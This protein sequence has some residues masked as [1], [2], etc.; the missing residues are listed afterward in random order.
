[1]SLLPG[2][3]NVLRQRICEL[4]I[5]LLYPRKGTEM[6]NRSEIWL[7]VLEDLG[8]TCSVSTREDALYVQT[9]VSAE[10]DSFFTVTLPQFA[11]DLEKSL[12]TGELSSDSFVGFGRRTLEL[13]VLLSPGSSDFNLKTKKMHWG[14]PL[15]LSGFTRRLFMEPDEWYKMLNNGLDENGDMPEH[16]V[17]PYILHQPPCVLVSPSSEEEADRMADAIFSVRQ[18][19]ALFSKEKS[20]AP[21][22]AEKRAIDGYVQVDKELD[23]PL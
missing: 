17:F 15:F 22:K 9:R 14:V 7:S 4:R 11:K 6:K 23:R 2:D 1:M 18:L 12:A 8:N 5:G 16:R 20:P 21:A 19:C 13:D 10:G 3:G